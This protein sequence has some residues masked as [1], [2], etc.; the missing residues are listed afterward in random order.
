MPDSVAGLRFHEVGPGGQGID[1]T[2]KNEELLKFDFEVKYYYK[3]FQPAYRKAFRFFFDTTLHIPALYR[4][5]YWTVQFIYN[6]RRF[7][8]KD[9]IRVLRIFLENSVLRDDYNIGPSG[10]MATLYGQRS[11]YHPDLD[12]SINYYRLVLDSL[13]ATGDLQSTQN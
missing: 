6:R 2:L 1:H 11:F 13:A 9:R 4:A 5:W 8:R 3:G 10:L 7:A 12:A